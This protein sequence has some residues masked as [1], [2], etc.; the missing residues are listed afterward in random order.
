[1]NVLKRAFSD[2]GPPPPYLII[3]GK[4]ASSLLFHYTTVSPSTRVR[5]ISKKPKPPTIHMVEDYPSGEIHLIL[6]YWHH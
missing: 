1:M 5:I 2:I 6:W 4:V 3:F